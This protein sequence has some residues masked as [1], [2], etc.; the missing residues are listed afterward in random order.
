MKTPSATRRKLSKARFAGASFRV[1]TA[2]GTDDI[3]RFATER[4]AA[5]GVGEPSLTARGLLLVIDPDEGLVR[6]EVGYSLEGVYP[7]AFIAYID[8]LY[9]PL[10]RLVNSSTTLT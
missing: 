5:I 1:I 2:S 8:R 3:N 4:F 7:D 9:N 6:L 10:R